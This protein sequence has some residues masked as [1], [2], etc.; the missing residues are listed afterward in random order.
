MK[1]Q[2]L[3][4]NSAA[5]CLLL[6]VSG[7]ALAA[8]DRTCDAKII[9]NETVNNLTV[10]GTACYVSETVVL[11]NV[12]VTNSPTFAMTNNQ[13]Q[14]NITVTGDGDED[15]LIYNTRVWGGPLTVTGAGIVWIFN[16]SI[17][18]NPETNNMVFENNK[19]EV[20]IFNNIV[21]G[22]LLCEGGNN[23]VVASN[24]VV[25]GTDTCQLVGTP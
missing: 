4:V 20:D 16:N 11:G 5:A 14:G 9:N 6:G 1:S 12:T 2:K 21:G 18:T 19:D 22:D 24:N 7:A 25:L 10:N 23:A 3:L 8:E 13:V 15:V 17:M